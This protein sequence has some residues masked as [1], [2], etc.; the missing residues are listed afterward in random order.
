MLL[1]IGPKMKFAIVIFIVIPMVRVAVQHMGK[2]AVDV[3]RRT[4]FDKKCRQNTDS[5]R[6]GKC[7]GRDT[8]FDK[9]TCTHR[10]NVHEVKECCDDNIVEDLM[11]QVQSLF[12]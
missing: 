4:T 6:S 9:K 8:Q 5:G 10:C 7:K 1:K 2:Y 3:V 11:E 12:Y